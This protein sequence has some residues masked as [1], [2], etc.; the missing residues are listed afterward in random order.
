VVE[1]KVMVALIHRCVVQVSFSQ[2]SSNVSAINH[3]NPD[4]GVF[5]I[6]RELGWYIW[7]FLPVSLAAGENTSRWVR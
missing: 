7:A 2:R 1:G 3:F 5:M 4:F 6:C